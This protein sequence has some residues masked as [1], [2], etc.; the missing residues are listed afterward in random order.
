MVTA[1]ARGDNTGA[2]AMEDPA[3][4]AAAPAAK[5]GQLW[6][7]FVT[8]YGAFEEVGAVSTATQPPYIIATVETAFA[9]ATVALAVTVTGAGLVGG[10]HVANGATASPE[11]SSS[12]ASYVN[13]GSFTESAVVVGSVPW[14]LPGTL[15]MPNGTGPFPAAV[16]VQGSGPSDRDET[17][18]PNKPF[19]DLAWGLASAGIAVLRYD[20]RSFVYPAAI[21]ARLASLT[22][23]QETTD[24]AVAA[25][26]LL[27]STP[28]VDPGR[29]VLIGHSLGAY[30]A[31]RIAVQAPGELRALV[32]L[33]APSTPLAQIILA[34][35]AY[36]ASLQ[37]SPGPSSDAQLAAL[38][39]QVA[40]AESPG[41]SPSTPASELPLG[42]PASYWLDLRT[43]DPLATAA[44]L[45]IPM[46]FSQG[47]RD[48]QVPPSELAAWQRALAGR[49]DVAF[50]TYPAL[51]HLLFT[52][53]GPSTPAEYTTPGQ[54]VAPELVADLAAWISSH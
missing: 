5:L 35:A 33:E 16:L 46:F 21:E 36:L 40:L 34:Q 19:R 27:R 17:V 52:G 42:I 6:Q 50:R 38:R 28:K 48:Y 20:K 26:A 31:P 10:L 24:D 14:S 54:H 30:L 7:S 25:I 18:G 53:T 49:S 2:E 45:R 43:Y 3:M 9:N 15:S 4:L 47:G 1:L 12:P 51:D 22:V 23:R 39:T 8:Q 41:L 37:G 44:G 13:P 11:P 32:L 29:I